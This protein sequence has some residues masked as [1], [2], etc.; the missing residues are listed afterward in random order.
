M[1]VL[2]SGDDDLPDSGQ[3]E[4]KVA[5]PKV[6]RRRIKTKVVKSVE[7]EIANFYKL[8]GQYDLK[9]NTI[10][11][12]IIHGDGSLSEKKQ[13]F[14]DIKVKCVNCKRNVGTRFTTNDRHLRAICGDINNPCK[15][16]I[17]IK[18]GTSELFSSL[19]RQLSHDL[20]IAKMRII[21]IKLKLLF[22][23][24]TEEQMEEAF[25]E[26]KKSYKSLVIGNNVVQKELME[27]QLVSP[28]EV[29]PSSLSI[30]VSEDGPK[31][32]RRTL[33]AANENALAGYISNFKG[34]IKEYEMDDSADT[35]L[36]KMRE[37]IDIYLDNI[38]PTL[39]IIRNTL[40]KINTVVK[41]KKQYHLIQIKVPLNEEVL[42][43]ENPEIISN[44]K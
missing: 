41:H 21:K 5:A 42:N 4:A 29:M 28:K 20:N 12:R 25:I 33:A 18:L 1:S 35:K 14:K 36:S 24:V 27:H 44:K 30:A 34:L 16:N 8:K 40:F 10:K 13:E 32:P 38:I 11:L 23:L 9:Y 39:D 26:I 31:V 37:A 19:E 7:D 6:K 22:D 3:V 15:L 43:T 2:T 17:D